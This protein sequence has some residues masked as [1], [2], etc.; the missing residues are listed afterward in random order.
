MTDL[1]QETPQV[2]KAPRTRH[3]SHV[4]VLHQVPYKVYA[5]LT[6]ADANRHLKMAYHDGTLEIVSPNLMRHEVASR[7]LSTI[8]TTVANRWGLA[9]DGAGGATFRRGGSGVYQGKG[10]EPDGSY[11]F[12]S[13]D[14]LPRDREPDLDAGDPPP[15]LWIEVDNRASSKGKL[16]VYAALGVPEVWR[17]RSGRKTLAFLR[18]NGDV[19]EPID[20]SLALPALT[21]ALV[22]EA[23]GLGE[24]KIDSEWM[25]LL[26]D[27]VAR[28]IGPAAGGA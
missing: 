20:R 22:L 11:Y 2:A 25:P 19:Y 5:R 13:V 10:K 23:L 27:W 26:R 14:R 1:I 18:L 12:A 21:P 7:R 8:V 15:D 17:Y 28:T 24:N 4:T 9:Y 16:P 3:R 6:Q